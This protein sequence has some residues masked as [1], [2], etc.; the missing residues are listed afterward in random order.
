MAAA[1]AARG[2]RL[3]TE[4]TTR[5]SSGPRPSAYPG[6][7]VVRLRADVAESIRIPHT[8]RVGMPNGR[9][10]LLIDPGARGSGDPVDLRAI[11]LLRS[12]QQIRLEPVPGSEAIRDIWAL[13]F[14]LP[15]REH[16]A[17]VFARATDIANRVEVFNLYRP[18]SMDAM[19]E[20]I[21]RVETLMAD[22]SR[23]RDPVRE[24]G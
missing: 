9:V 14:L 24:A 15:T 7:A 2:H 22:R 20:V 23:S 17:A 18:M 3:L 4:D 5:I 12:G 21:D 8:T 1:F 16:R 6:P 11:I 19:D 10:A 13:S